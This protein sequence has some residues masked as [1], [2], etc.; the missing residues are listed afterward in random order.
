MHEVGW[1]IMG[2]F[3]IISVSYTLHLVRQKILSNSLIFIFSE[4]A[5]SQLVS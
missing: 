4:S 5:K 1:L 3:K 2:F